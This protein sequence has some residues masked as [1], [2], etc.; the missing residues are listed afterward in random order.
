MIRGAIEE[1]WILKERLHET[2][3]GNE[4]MSVDAALQSLGARSEKA[5][6]PMQKDKESE[7]QVKWGLLQR[8]NRTTTATPLGQGIIELRKT[9]VWWV[10]KCC[11]HIVF[12][13]R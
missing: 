13:F 9:T 8:D 3:R 11:F 12:L 2:V 4:L 7:R 10:S 6:S 1:R 5:L